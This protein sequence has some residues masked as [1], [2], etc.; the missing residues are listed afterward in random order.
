MQLLRIALTGGLV[1][2]LALTI[3]IC[4]HL[5]AEVVKDRDTRPCGC[6]TC[7]RGTTRGGVR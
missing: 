3:W 1:L 4:G 6:Q 2:S 7:T 5:I